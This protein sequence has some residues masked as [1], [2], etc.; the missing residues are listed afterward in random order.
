MVIRPLA[1][2][3]LP[4]SHRVVVPDLGEIWFWRSQGFYAIC[5][6]AEHHGRSLSVEEGSD[7]CRL[8]DDRCVKFRT[9]RRRTTGAPFRGRPLGFLMAWLQEQHFHNYAWMHKQEYQM[10]YT[11]RKAARALLKQLER[12]WLLF[13]CERARDEGEPE[14]HPDFR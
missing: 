9:H 13:C 6:G 11:D 1:D 7:P 12:A 14:E 2:E 5:H 3:D 8:G 4:F 10:T